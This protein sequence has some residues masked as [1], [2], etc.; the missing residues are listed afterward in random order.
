ML[1]EK[2]DIVKGDES[3]SWLSDPVEIAFCFSFGMPSSATYHQE[4]FD[5]SPV[6]E[7][8][9]MSEVMVSR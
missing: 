5:R 4:S 9:R 2:A 1:T 8:L 6:V 7:I 3:P